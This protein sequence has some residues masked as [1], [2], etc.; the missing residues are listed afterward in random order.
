MD[1]VTQGIL[2]ALNGALVTEE[3]AWSYDTQIRT[4]THYSATTAS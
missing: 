3:A 1:G 2:T 4:I